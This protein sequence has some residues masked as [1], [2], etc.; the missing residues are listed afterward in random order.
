MQLIHPSRNDQEFT[1][2]AKEVR[3]TPLARQIGTSFGKFCLRKVAAKSWIWNADAT[4]HFQVAV[5]DQDAIAS[6]NART[7]DFF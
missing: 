5:R 4:A 7:S 6:P 3:R 2:N 1:A